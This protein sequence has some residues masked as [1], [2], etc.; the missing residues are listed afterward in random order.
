[1]KLPSFVVDISILLTATSYL[2]N[3]LHRVTPQENCTSCAANPLAATYPD[4]PTGLINSTISVHL[5][6]YAYA[7]ALIPS[8]Y[9]ILTTAYARFGIPASKY[10]IIIETTIDHDIRYEG[11]NAVSDFSA[12]H[13]EFPFIDRLS[14]GLTSFR[15]LRYLYLPPT[16]P[17]AIEGAEGYG[18]IVLPS[19]F[20]PPDAG[21]TITPRGLVSFKVYDVGV[22]NETV[23]LPLVGHALF[24]FTSDPTNI[25][26][27]PLAFY[28]NVTRQP[29]FSINSTVCDN[30][31]RLWDTSV[32]IG[33]ADVRP[34]SIFGSVKLSPPVVP[35]ETVFAEAFGVVAATAFMEDNYVSCESLRGAGSEHSD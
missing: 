25:A 18:E 12:F 31:I 24:K 19:F 1:M 32:T 34:R 5:V 4:L 27:F 21:Y 3:A 13:V 20:D 29:Q 6:S 30:Q 35:K 2:A 26:P 15:F 17:I 10:P 8:Q 9:P 33:S 14:D 11:I 23:N 22:V 16:V 28:K 7:R